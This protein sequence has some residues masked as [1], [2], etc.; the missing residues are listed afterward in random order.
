MG[1]GKITNLF[2][3]SNA[4][5]IFV[6]NPNIERLGLGY[7][8]GED[9]SVPFINRI[10]ASFRWKPPSL[11]GRWINPKYYMLTSRILNTWREGDFP[12][13]NFFDLLLAPPFGVG[14]Q[15]GIVFVLPEIRPLRV[16]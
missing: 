9:H 11:I 15:F 16:R 13:E 14:Q 6:S 3:V 5:T 1:I 10:R 4:H 8:T 7:R 12:P 2:S